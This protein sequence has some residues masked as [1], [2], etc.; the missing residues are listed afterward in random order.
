MQIRLK[1]GKIVEAAEER[2]ARGSRHQA[3]STSL[4]QLELQN[5][6]AWLG[7]ESGTGTGTFAR[8]LLGH[9][10]LMRQKLSSENP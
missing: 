7:E 1:K 6:S 9:L 8:G 3:C 10:T 4:G 2:T 5:E